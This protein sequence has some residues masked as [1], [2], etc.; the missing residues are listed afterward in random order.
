MYDRRFKLTSVWETPYIHDRNGSSI[1][2][3]WAGLPSDSRR[4]R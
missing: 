3:S 2:S 4:T 1:H